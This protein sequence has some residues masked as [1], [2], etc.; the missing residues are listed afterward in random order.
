MNLNDF[1]GLFLAKNKVA[2][3]RR[4]NRPFREYMVEPLTIVA[5]K[6]NIYTLLM[7]KYT[8]GLNTDEE[9]D[10]LFDWIDRDEE[11]SNYF[12]WFTT[13]VNPANDSETQKVLAFEIP[14]DRTSLKMTDEELDAVM[15]KYWRH[16]KRLG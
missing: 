15:E 2:A 13:L 14:K 11:H 12:I 9:D 4:V 16:V 1:K 8:L 6:E 7:R 5:M 10:V 3:E